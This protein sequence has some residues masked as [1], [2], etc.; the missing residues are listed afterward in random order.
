MGFGL[1]Y[2][3]KFEIIE[4]SFHDA[5][6]KR[7]LDL[8]EDLQLDIKKRVN[9]L[10][11]FEQQK[12]EIQLQHAREKARNSGKSRRFKFKSVKFNDARAPKVSR[13]ENI[14]QSRIT[15]SRKGILMVL[16]SR[17]SLNI[18]SLR[19]SLVFAPR[20]DSALYVSRVC[21]TRIYT[22][23]QQCRV[24][25]CSDLDIFVEQCP[26]PVIENCLNIRF[27]VLDPGLKV[28]DFSWLRTDM[29]SPNYAITV[30]S[31]CDWN[32]LQNYTM[33]DVKLLGPNLDFLEFVNK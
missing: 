27:H 29:A 25:D 24:H 2:K 23:C 20:I 30:V 26:N 8:I 5:N 15:Q 33:D 18:E 10:S 9:S 13:H 28:S 12:Y 16:D 31:P 32:P 17:P 3:R 21:Q 4:E 11:K 14:E 1:D 7:T 19:D 6:P 22:R